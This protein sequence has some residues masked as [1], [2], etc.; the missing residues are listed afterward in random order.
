MTRVSENSTSYALGNSLAKSKTYLEDLQLKGSNLKTIQK[1]SDNP[2]GST[3]I[4][5]RKSRTYDSLQFE[6]SANAA[7]TNLEFTENAL[8]D[9]SDI[10]GRAKELAIAQSSDTFDAGARKTVA[11]EIKQ[12]FQ[13]AV[14]VANKRLGQRYIFSGT[15]TLTKPFTDDGRYQGDNGK[16]QVEVGKDRFLQV[17][18]SGAE[19]FKLQSQ[20]TAT[21]P[22]DTRTLA[23]AEEPKEE[24][25]SLLSDL[26]SFTNA[27]ETDTPE[28]VRSLLE[29]FDQH[30]NNIVEARTR[31]GSIINTLDNVESHT[32][33]DAVTNKSE[34]SKIEDV[35]V[36]EL[37]SDLKK[38]QNVLD[39]TYR[40]SAQVLNKNLMHF[41][42]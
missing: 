13:Q 40:T 3:E 30:I 42:G 35:D 33:R 19:L 11:Q 5:T 16:I 9:L 6:R 37:F 39:A 31:I 34:L 17:N 27:L 21:A 29:K 41:L 2:T 8:N 10:V 20:P 28:I 7:R 26:K 24:L 15:K 25:P 18:I 22:Q 4:L 12:L 38:Q 23:S 14:S 32:D 1:P 36:L